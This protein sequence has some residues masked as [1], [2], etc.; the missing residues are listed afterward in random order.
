MTELGLLK[1]ALLWARNQIECG[2]KP[3][4]QDA[5]IQRLDSVI[6][7]HPPTYAELRRFYALHPAPSAPKPRV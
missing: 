2:I 6:G 4:H 7:A 1:A 3:E 5:V